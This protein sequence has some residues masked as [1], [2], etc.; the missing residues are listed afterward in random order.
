[1]SAPYD[2]IVV[3]LGAMGA[4]ALYQ[5]AK[6]GK[7][8]L[9]IDR[10][11]P[12][13]AFGSSHGESRITRLAIG[14]GTHFTPLA[15]RSHEIWRELERETGRSL[16][17]TTGGLVIGGHEDA[18][19]LHVANFLE[20]TIEAASRYGIRHDILGADEI[21]RRFPAFSPRDDEIG[22]YE[23]DAGF[24]RPEACVEVQLDLARR[25]GAEIRNSTRVLGI[26]GDG[27]TTDHGN[28]RAERIIVAAGPW[29]SDLLSDAC[30]NIFRVYRQVMFW[31]EIDGPAS[32]FQ[33][34]NFPIFIWQI[35]GASHGIYGF[36]DVGGDGA[37]KIAGEQYDVTTSADEMMREISPGEIARMHERNV[38]PFLKNVSTRCTR[39][40]AC[41]YTVTPDAGFVV[42]TMPGNESAVIVSACSGHGF[43]HSA[44]LGEAVAELIVDG[45]SRLDL[46][47]FRLGRFTAKGISPPPP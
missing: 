10:F 16:M 32:P 35:P 47:A 8:V 18:A 33:P 31:F 44:A 19:P 12:P 25:H 13:H 1:M 36:P 21:R 27:V 45:R 14:E 42:D 4:A 43:K 11:V 22:Y 39:A 3:G 5:L 37:I 29:I 6:R 15:M 40:L 38:R 17:T 41:L 24:L 20:Q 34:G 9:G 30:E 26:E 23:H 46:S 2:V 28:F 7:R